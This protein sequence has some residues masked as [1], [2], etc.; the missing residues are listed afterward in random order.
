MSE[1][2]RRVVGLTVFAFIFMASAR[3]TP[4]VRLDAPSVV[5]VGQ[6]FSVGVFADGVTDVDPIL[7]H[8]ELLAFGFNVGFPS[9]HVTFDGYSI[10][11]PFTD[12]TPLLGGPFAGSTFPGVEGDNI[13]LATL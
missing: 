7:G 2:K 4:F 6:A 5:E 11:P 1:M 9:S 8:D 10:A 12:D 13:Q 3:A